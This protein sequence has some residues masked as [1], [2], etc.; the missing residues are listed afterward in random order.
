MLNTRKSLFPLQNV[1]ALEATCLIAAAAKGLITGTNSTTQRTRFEEMFAAQLDSDE[2][3]GFP[4]GRSA[5]AALLTVNGVNPGDEVL[6]TGFTCDAVA[7]AIVAIGATPRWVD[8]DVQTL[9]MDPAQ[10]ENAV[11]AST[12][13]II[14]QHSFGI[15]ARTE[16]FQEIVERHSLALIEDCCLALGSNQVDG[17]M[18]GTGQYDAF[19]SFEVTKTI[20]AGWGGVALIKDRDRAYEIRKIR[21]GAGTRGR[22]YSV[23]TLAQAAISSLIYRSRLNRW[24]AYIP[25]VMYKIGLFSFSDKRTGGMTSQIPFENYGSAGPDATWR[26]LSRQLKR[27]PDQLQRLRSNN[28]VYFNALESVGVKVPASWTAETSVLIRI[29]IL[30]KNRE[31]FEAHMW[32]NNVDTGRW[33][34]SPVSAGNI[35]NTFGYTPG[36]CLT[37]E[38]IASSITNL[39]THASMSDLQVESSVRAMAEYFETH[40][41]ESDY[42]NEQISELSN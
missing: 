22:I 13:A 39:P 11:N 32:R 8:I 33:F 25:A 19:W 27:L 12:R 41:G 17:S 21:D 31:E 40:K 37:G 18:I 3:V 1:T 24:L 7:Q 26:L 4:S 34:D 6:V 5:L 14:V 15:P 38:R 28:R 2:A 16:Q 42:M 29:P 23:K 9:A 35:Q 30:V 10:A 36:T 20:S